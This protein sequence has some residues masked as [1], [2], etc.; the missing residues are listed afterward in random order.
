VKRVDDG[1]VVRTVKKVNFG[2]A[3]EVRVSDGTFGVE[4]DGPSAKSN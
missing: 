3:L 4:V 2:D 1:T